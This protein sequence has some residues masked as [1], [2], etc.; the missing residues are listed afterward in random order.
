MGPPHG[1]AGAGKGSPAVADVILPFV[2]ETD[3]TLPR[4]IRS[5]ASIS[6]FQ[7]GPGG[8]AAG[9]ALGMMIHLGPRARRKLLFHFSFV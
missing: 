1:E 7:Q 5:T 4:Q 3:K 8:A 6:G 2:V 9:E